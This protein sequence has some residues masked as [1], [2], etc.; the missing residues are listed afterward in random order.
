VKVLRGLGERVRAGDSYALV[1]ALLLVAVVVTIVAPDET[2]GRLLRDAVV[3]A[4]VVVTY[5]TATARRAVLVPRVVVPSIALVLVVVGAFEGATTDAVAGGIGAVLA[6]GLAV[7]ITRDLFDRHRV[8]V[9]TVMGVLS[10]YILVGLLFA[11]LYRLVAEVDP[12][13]FYTRGDDGSAGEHMYFSFVAIT[14]TGFG[15]LTPADSLGK[16]LAVLEIIVGQLYLVTVVA[17]IVTAATGAQLIRRRR[18]E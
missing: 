9:E 2:W 1:L 18:E 8:D 13:S 7:L 15:D 6:A 4:A 10:L 11:C 14:T 16:A 3:A 17:V 5:W 12:G